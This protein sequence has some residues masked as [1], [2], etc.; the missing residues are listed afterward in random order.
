MSLTS[1]VRNAT[2]V[3]ELIA[4][5]FPKPRTRLDAE[6][7]V[8]SVA[9]ARG[10]IGTA[11]DYLLRFIL[12]REMPFAQRKRWA[13]ELALARLR[14]ARSE[15]VLVGEKLE[16]ASDIAGRMELM[17]REARL[18]LGRF[19]AGKPRSAKLIR[20]ALDLA[21]CDLYYRIGL[22]DPRFGKAPRT[23]EL[24]ELKRLTDIAQ[25]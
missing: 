11:Y 4:A 18:E 7:R 3:R 5:W 16:D 9:K 8:A 25:P 10:L 21:H 22:L 14:R 6:L 15:L 20:C 23:D 13:A 19:V 12:E 2:P 1:L 17:I 24:T